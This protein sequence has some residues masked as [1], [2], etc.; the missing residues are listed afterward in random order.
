MPTKTTGKGLQRV[1][2]RVW[3]VT[4][5]DKPRPREHAAKGAEP[6]CAALEKRK[7][8]LGMYVKIYSYE[9]WFCLLTILMDSQVSK[10]LKQRFLILL[11]CRPAL[12]LSLSLSLIQIIRSAPTNCSNYT[13]ISLR[14]CADQL[15]GLF[16]S[17]FNE[18]LATS[19]IPTSFKK[20]VII[21]VPKNSKPSCLNDY[22]PVALTSTVMKVFER[23][24][25]KHICSS[26][27]ATLDPLQFAYRPNRSTDDAISQVLHSSLTH[28]DSKNGN[29]VRLLFI[30]YSSAFN[31]IVPSKLAVKLSDLGLNTTLCDWIQ[32][33]LTGRPQVVKMGQFTSNSI[34]LNVGA[35]QG[36]VLSP[37]LYSLYT[38]DCVSSHSSTSIVKFADDTVVLGLISNNDETAYLGEVERLTSWCQDNCLSL[39]VSKTK[40]L[41]VDFRKRQQRPYT[42]LMISGTP[43]ERVSSFKYLGVNISEDLTWTAHIQ[44]QVKKARQRLYHLRQLRKFRVSPAILKTFYSGAIES[45]LT[46]C[47]SVWYSN[48]TK[49]DCKALQRVVRLAERISGSALPS[50]Q[51]I[52]LKRC[53][54]RAAKIIKDSNHSGNCLFTLLPSGKRFRSMMAKTER[55]RRSFYPQAIRLLNSVSYHL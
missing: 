27:P 54:S 38:H 48:A 34:T 17:I 40:E 41:I 49:Q 9:S 16:T 15:A 53:R 14:S 28:I 52:Y 18:S 29:Y 19:V 31:T 39:N 55:L 46:Q 37:L 7:R 25:K 3:Y 24:L 51:D 21:P 33:F 12:H 10:S 1:T 4:D 22:R 36:C 2:S 8:K 30:D 35:P 32:D 13:L 42:P 44:T 6:C 11:L 23:L 26:I 50:L 5:P 43:V 20:S 45:V 47:I